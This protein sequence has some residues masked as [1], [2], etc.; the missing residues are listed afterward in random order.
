MTTTTEHVSAETHKHTHGP[1]CGHE[2]VIHFDHVD[3]IQDGHAHREHDGH[4]DECTTCTCGNCSDNCATCTCKDCTCE[5][6]SH[7][8]CSCGSCNCTSCSSCNCADCT[9]ATCRHAA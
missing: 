2:A 9:C 8:A 4:Y 3:Y 7:N 1:S 6:C 5:N